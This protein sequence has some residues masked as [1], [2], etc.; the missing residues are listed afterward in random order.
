[1]TKKELQDERRKVADDL[2]KA[3]ADVVRL[4]VELTNVDQKLESHAGEKVAEKFISDRNKKAAD[5]PNP[6]KAA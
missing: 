3:E 5:A 1:M 4:N 2:E 6:L